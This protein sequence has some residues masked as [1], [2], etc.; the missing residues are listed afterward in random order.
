MNGDALIKIGKLY[1]RLERTKTKK[2]ELK[3]DLALKT[4]EFQCSQEMVVDLAM[5]LA[6]SE[7]SLDNAIQKEHEMIM[8]EDMHQ[9]EVAELEDELAEVQEDN[10]SLEADYQ[11]LWHTKNVLEAAVKKMI[12][13]QIKTAHSSFAHPQ[14]AQSV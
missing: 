8:A 1:K 6:E 9:Q 5:D 2:R 13:L 10:E 14:V 12:A 4:L 11:Q 7:R 3:K